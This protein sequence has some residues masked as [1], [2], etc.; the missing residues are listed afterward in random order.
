MTKELIMVIGHLSWNE[1]RLKKQIEGQMRRRGSK[2]KFKR[3][4]LLAVT[5]FGFYL[6]YASF[7]SET[8]NI[9]SELIPVT[10]IQ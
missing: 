8:N 4:L 9:P 7:T 5:L 3:L 6:L 1:R 10:Q 2:S